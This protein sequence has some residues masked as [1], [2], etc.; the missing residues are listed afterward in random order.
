MKLTQAMMISPRGTP[1]PIPTFAA[2]ESPEGDEADEQEA[3][4]DGE[5]DVPTLAFVVRMAKN[6]DS[7]ELRFGLVMKKAYTPCCNDASGAHVKELPLLNA[8]GWDQILSFRWVGERW[9]PYL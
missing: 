2:S 9:K 8:E 3:E 4:L 6:G 1:T 5:G 7:L